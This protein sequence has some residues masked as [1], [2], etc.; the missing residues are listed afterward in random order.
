M[1]SIINS[2]NLI[3][4]E[5]F[6]VKVEIDISR[7]IPAFNIVGLPSTEVREARERVKSAVIN[8]GYDFPNSRIVVNLSPADMRKEGSFLDL[9]MS[10][11]ILR[12]YINKKDSYLNESIFVGELS[13]DGHLRK[14]KGILPLVI[15]AKKEKFKR[16]FIPYDNF[17]ESNFIDGIDII[18]IK[19]LN[20][21]Q[22][23]TGLYMTVLD[24]FK[25]VYIGQTTRD[26]KERILR[27]W[28]VKPKFDRIL[29]GGVNQSVISYDSYGVLDTSRIFIIYE[30]DKNKI[31]KIEERLVK[32]IPKEYQAN[33]IGGG[34]HLDSLKDLLDAVDTM[35]LRNLEN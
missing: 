6:L 33:R 12:K 17:N 34:I 15:G 32:E 9:P 22:K 4:I 26:L 1:L 25:Q 16:I 7:G 28:K 8:A 2:N 21:C 10:V 29:F 23:Q 5:S 14:V 35:N 24:N 13:L 18:P 11:G 20:E 31:D 30:T 27:H 3:G 19:N